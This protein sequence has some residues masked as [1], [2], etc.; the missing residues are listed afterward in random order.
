MS[1][2]EFAGK[3]IYITGST[4]GMGLLAGKMLAALGADIATFDR[5]PTDS[6]RQAF[7]SARRLPY[8]RIA[9]YQLNMVD[10]DTTI[11]DKD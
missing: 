8:Q 1:R 6:G 7:E 2:N 9:R 3:R 11:M 10:R 4:S 5:N